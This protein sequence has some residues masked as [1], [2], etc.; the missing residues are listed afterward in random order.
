MI[1]QHSKTLLMMKHLHL[2]PQPVL[3]C[4]SKGRGIHLLGVSKT[5]LI[6]EHECNVEKQEPIPR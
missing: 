2:S 5:V 6:L 4:K 3:A 1:K